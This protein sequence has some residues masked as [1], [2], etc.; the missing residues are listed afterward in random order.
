MRPLKYP[1]LL[2]SLVLP[3]LLAASVLQPAATGSVFHDLNGN[4]RRERSEP[5][6]PGVLVSNSREIVETDAQGNWSLPVDDDTIFFVIKPNDWRTPMDAHNVAKF[7][8]VHKPSGSPEVR[9][10]GV[11]PT[12]PLPASIDFAL[13]PRE[14]PRQFTAAFLGD[15]QPYTMDEVQYTIHDVTKELKGTEH[16]FA[17]VLGDVV[18]DNLDLLPP[19]IEGLGKIGLPFYYV[20]GNHDIDF[21]VPSDEHSDE[22]WNRLLGPTYYSFNEGGVHFMVLENVEYKG[23]GNGYESALGAEQMEWV[24]NNLAR[25]PKDTL[26]VAMMHIPLTQTKEKDE[27]LR[28]LSQF[29][30]SMSL[31]AHA[32]TQ[33]HL[34]ME[35]Q[36]GKPHHHLV[37]ATI[38]GSWWRGEKDSFGI[39]ISMMRDGAPKGYAILEFDGNRL[40]QRYKATGLD[41]R[42]Q[43]SI[44]LPAEVGEGSEVVVNV[45]NGSPRCKVEM[46]VGETMGWVPMERVERVDPYY[47][48]LKQLEA[49]E[50]LPA[51]GRTLPG[52]DNSAHLWAGQL[53]KM[54]AGTY[55][56]DVRVTDLYGRTHSSSRVYTVR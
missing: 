7:Y 14:E 27:I 16:R 36:H 5:G 47:A 44:W 28:L 54:P 20:M 39:P 17:T 33:T 56:L 32:H 22:T 25:V 24:R 10:G 26:V 15:T 6:I 29:E 38:C 50:K 8:Y 31:S 18:G 46:R 52:A 19:L 40:T 45:Y 53:P 30:N 21:D 2:P 4:G 48:A 13:S 9:F 43:M 12:G 55:R 37:T 34:F 3:A 1:T 51:T 35:H 49:E 11:K 42:E 41:P 23:Q